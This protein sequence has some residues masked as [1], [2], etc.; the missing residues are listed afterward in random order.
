ML[1][2]HC[3]VFRKMLITYAGRTSTLMAAQI[4]LAADSHIFYLIFNTVKFSTAELHAELPLHWLLPS[5]CTC[6]QEL[7]VQDHAGPHCH[8][9]DLATFLK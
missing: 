5:D 4:H 8:G 7:S 3:W 6:M 2:V 1:L 9:Q